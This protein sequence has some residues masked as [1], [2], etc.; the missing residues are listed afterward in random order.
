MF[1][2]SFGASSFSWFWRYWN[3]VYSYYLNR[4]CYRP[5]RK[6]LPRPLAKMA[7]FAASGFLLH[8]LPFGW[9][10]RVLKTGSVPVPFVALWFTIMAIFALGG[11]RMRLDYSSLPFS[12]RVAFNSSQITV[13][14]FLALLIVKCAQ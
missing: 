12:I 13:A 14:G 8:D 10:I 5:L 2:R 9:G 1:I 3:P 11:T 6:V 7:T 4:F